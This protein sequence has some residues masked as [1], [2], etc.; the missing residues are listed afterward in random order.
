M[1]ENGDLTIGILQSI[2][3]NRYQ[4]CMILTVVKFMIVDL[5]I[6]VK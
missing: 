3:V 5:L 2:S 6:L 4:Y 1:L